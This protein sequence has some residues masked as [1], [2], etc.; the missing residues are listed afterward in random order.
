MSMRVFIKAIKTS[1]TRQQWLYRLLFS[2]RAR[3]YAVCEALSIVSS[4]IAGKPILIGI[5]VLLS[6]KP[7]GEIKY[8]LAACLRFKNEAYYLR[9]WIEFHRRI[10]IEHF[11]LYNNNSTD[12]FRDVIAPYVEQK[13]VTLHDWSEVPASPGADL[14]CITRYRDE[15]RWIAFLDADEFLLPVGKTS[16]TELLRKFEDF[17]ALAVNWIYFGSNGHL[18]RPHGGVLENYTKRSAVPNRHV[19]SIV[20]PRKVIKYGNSHY[21]FY[22]RAALPVNTQVTPVY[23]SFSEPAV[24]DV[25][26]INHYYSKSREE[27]LAK[28][29]MKSWVD[30]EGSRFP[31]RTVDAWNRIAS[32]NNDVE[33]T[34]ACHRVAASTQELCVAG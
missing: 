30:S 7:S 15:A 8:N 31:S 12:D 27:F 14:H 23:G 11:Y 25:L 1:L 29:V 20:N 32:D 22:S 24:A 28:A 16:L 13:L 19:K 4:K 3:I 2:L 33:D 6:S 34:T 9:E 5:D 17:P 10:G 21:W 18:K 26:R